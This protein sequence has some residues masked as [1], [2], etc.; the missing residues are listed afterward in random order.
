MLLLFLISVFVYLMRNGSLVIMN[1]TVSQPVAFVNVTLPIKPM[2]PITILN[3]SGS[4]IPA[5]LVN[6]QLVIPVLGNGSFTIEYVP[7]T[8]TTPDGFLNINVT[9]EY[10]INLY[11]NNVLL[12]NFPM[13]L[14]LNFTKTSNG[15]LLQ[16]APGNYTIE[17]IPQYTST[18]TPTTTNN[19]TTSN[20]TTP[21]INVTKQTEPGFINYL[22]YIVVAIVIA[23]ILVYLFVIR[24]RSS[25][26]EPV[27][28]EGLNP[29]DKEVLKAIAE[30]GGDVYQVDLQKKLNMPKATL[31][32]SIR[33]LEEAGYVMV[34]KE[35]KYN[36]I[37]LVKKPD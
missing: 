23:V 35:G 24:G 29:T 1:V 31:W 9:S 15:Y 11:A 19:T 21:T 4:T 8:S 2:G 20:E 26:P 30:L 34:I 7:R 32:R 16:I 6:N 14:L 3:S 25:S 5:I 37:K 33:R 10:P 28:I 27:I 12:S 18:V 13:N 22:V 36:K 17:F